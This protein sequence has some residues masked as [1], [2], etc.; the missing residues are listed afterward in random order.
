MEVSFHQRRIRTSPFE[1]T[2]HMAH[3][4]RLVAGAFAPDRIGLDV[5]VEHLVRVQLGT[6]ARHEEQAY[7]GR[8]FLQP[9]THFFAAMNRVAIYNDEYLAVALFHQSPQEA[10]EEN[11]DH[12][13]GV[14][15][16]A[17]SKSAQG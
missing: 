4:L 9:L 14:I 17:K 7:P 12:A 3:Q 15:R 16:S 13:F 8:I 5:L 11:F 1:V 2:T 10:Q 6:V